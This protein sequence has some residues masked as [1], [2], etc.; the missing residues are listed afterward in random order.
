MANA[1]MGGKGLAGILLQMFL[2][3]GGVSLGWG[4]I[5]SNP[6]PSVVEPPGLPPSVRFGPVSAPPL[7]QDARGSQRGAEP[8]DSRWRVEVLED[9]PV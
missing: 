3:G 2:T 6:G 5:Y 9:L 7:R 4:A 1:I 8:V